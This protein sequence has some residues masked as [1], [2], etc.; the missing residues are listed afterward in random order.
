MLMPAVVADPAFWKSAV[1]VVPQ[2]AVAVFGFQFVVVYQAEP[3]PVFC[4]VLT[5]CACA[6]GAPKNTAHATQAQQSTTA[7]AGRRG[8]V[9]GLAVCGRDMSPLNE[10]VRKPRGKASSVKILS[11][12]HRK[13]GTP[14]NPHE[15]WIRVFLL[16][17]Q[18]RLF[19][20]K[21]TKEAGLS[22][23]R[24][25]GSKTIHTNRE[26]FSDFRS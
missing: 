18:K 9:R 21:D 24:G 13:L 1:S 20:H 17:L 4:Q 8:R 14:A 25:A 22:R 12:H 23:E 6:S 3:D 7:R 19:R 5:V 10:G 26:K 15:Y 11:H 2:L 16:M